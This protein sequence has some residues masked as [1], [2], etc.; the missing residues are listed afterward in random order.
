MNGA[1]TN[2]PVL[3]ILIDA[4]AHAAAP[5][6]ILQRHPRRQTPCREVSCRPEERACGTVKNAERKP[7]LERHDAGDCPPFGERAERQMIGE[8]LAAAVAT[9]SAEHEPVSA[10]EIRRTSLSRQWLV[11]II[12]YLLAEHRS[13]RTTPKAGRTEAVL[14][15]SVDLEKVY[16]ARN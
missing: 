2:T 6:R 3:K 8:P 12:E 14:A 5:N 16:A 11:L 1:G 13:R 15:E 9:R 10:I 7:G 4:A